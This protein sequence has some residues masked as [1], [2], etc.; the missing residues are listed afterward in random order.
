MAGPTHTHKLFMEQAMLLRDR[1]RQAKTGVV[2]KKDAS[3]GNPDVSIEAEG[4]PS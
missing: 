2:Y 4:D 3:T 1:D